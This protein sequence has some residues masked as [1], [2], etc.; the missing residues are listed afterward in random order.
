MKYILF[1]CSIFAVSCS[2]FSRIAGETRIGSEGNYVTVSNSEAN[3][4]S[5]TFGD[6][7]FAVSQRQFRNL[8]PGKPIFRNILFYAIADQPTYDYYVLENRKNRTIVHPDY[9]LKDTL[10]GKSQL[11][12]A[13]SKNAP[14]TDLD[15]IRSKIRFGKK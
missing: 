5:L 13:I 9:I 15:F 7:E 3:F 1:V 10:L 11:T 6:F 4:H 12:I 14:T 2:S 8:N